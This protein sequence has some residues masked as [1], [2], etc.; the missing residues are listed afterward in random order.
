MPLRLKA[1]TVVFAI[2]TT[3]QNSLKD[4]LDEMGI[5]HVEVGDCKRIGDA[6][7]AIRD[8]AEIGRLL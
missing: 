8:G 6:L 3:P 5:F 1:D 2:G 7:L 4:V